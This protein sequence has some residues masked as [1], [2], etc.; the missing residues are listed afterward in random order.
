MTKLQN[1]SFKAAL[2]NFLLLAIIGTLLRWIQWK[3]NSFINYHFLLN[4]HSHFAMGGWMFTALF[5]GILMVFPILSTKNELVYQRIF[6][7]SQ[8]GSYGMLL[9]FPFKG[10]SFIS[11]LFSEVYVIATYWFAYRVWQDTDNNTASSKWLKA[12]LI[13]LLV[14]SLGP[15]AVGPMMANHLSGSVWYF[16]AI[17]FYLHFQYNGWFTFAALALLFRFTEQRNT[18]LH[19][20]NEKNAFRL[21]TTATILTYLLST[22]W[23]SPGLAFNF[24]AGA[25]AV[26]QIAGWY[27]M[28]RLLISL[29]EQKL[30]S[31]HFSAFL[32]SV[33]FVAFTLKIFLQLLSVLQTV[34]LLAYRYKNLII[35]YLHLVLIG[36]LSIFLIAFFIENKV[37]RLTRLSKWGVLLFLLAFTVSEILLVSQALIARLNLPAISHQYPLVFLASCGMVT[38]L[39]FLLLSQFQNKYTEDIN[40]IKTIQKNKYENQN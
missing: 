1:Q 32:L 26:L 14:S 18:L 24:I 19:P 22:L 12:A 9:S 10:Y 4:A 36:F 35:A 28:L 17:Y 31:F 21:L 27:Y 37:L 33:S 29:K 16:D 11:I 5:T 8:I 6:W 34:S 3:G 40:S 38:G 25:G 7:L 23:S 20:K 39:L 13:F 15:Y 30:F 2:F